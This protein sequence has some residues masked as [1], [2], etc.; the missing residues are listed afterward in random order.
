MTLKYCAPEVGGFSVIAVCRLGAS[1]L[2]MFENVEETTKLGG[3]ET[4]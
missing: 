2:I 3:V 1:R 4:K